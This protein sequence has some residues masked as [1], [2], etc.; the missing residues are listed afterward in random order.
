MERLRGGS[1]F[2]RLEK[3]VYKKSRRIVVIKVEQLGGIITIIDHEQCLLVMLRLKDF[4]WFNN[5]RCDANL[6]VI[7]H[8]E[9][10]ILQ[11]SHYRRSRL[12]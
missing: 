5:Y 2:V 4:Q 3:K 1:T 11:I 9:M 7:F 6:H 8:I 12:N 10:I